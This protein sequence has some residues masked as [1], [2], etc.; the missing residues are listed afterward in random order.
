MHLLSGGTRTVPPV[1]HQRVLLIVP[2]GRD[3]INQEELLSL[4][5]WYCSRKF[6]QK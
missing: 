5:A 6:Q 2:E 4:I 3:I 1:H